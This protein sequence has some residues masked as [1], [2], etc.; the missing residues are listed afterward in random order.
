MMQIRYSTPNQVDIS[1]TVEDLRMVQR[2]LLDIATSGS[3]SCV[4]EAETDFDPS[5]Y[6]SLLQKIVVVKCQGPVKATIMRD[7][8]IQ[9]EASRENLQVFS[10]F[11]DFELNTP[12]G[13]HYHHEGY[14][15]NQHIASDSVPLVISVK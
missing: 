2:R 8:Y 1:G 13:H 9:V 14:E 3:I 7:E 12:S 4:I 15:E 5:P 6:A 11:F 10:S